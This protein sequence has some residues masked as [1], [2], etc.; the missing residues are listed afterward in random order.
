LAAEEVGPAVWLVFQVAQVAVALTTQPRLEA[1][2][3]VKV[4]LE[5]AGL[6]ETVET[7]TEQVVV[8]ALALLV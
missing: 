4:L 1:E 8:V 6:S 2:Q 5:V 7:H 3:A